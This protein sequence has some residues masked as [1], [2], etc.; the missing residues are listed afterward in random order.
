MSVEIERDCLSTLDEIVL[1]IELKEKELLERAYLHNA[2]VLIWP[3]TSNPPTFSEVAADNPGV[4][5]HVP[6]PRL[7]GATKEVSGFIGEP[8]YV[9]EPCAL[10]RW[11]IAALVRARE[12]IVDELTLLSTGDILSLSEPFV[13][14]RNQ[15]LFL[16]SQIA[17]LKQEVDVRAEPTIQDNGEKGVSSDDDHIHNKLIWNGVGW[18]LYFKGYPK[19]TL[20]DYLGFRYLAVLLRQPK[21]SFFP[22]DLET[23]VHGDGK[24][25][26]LDRF[27]SLK[28]KN[29]D[30]FLLS[31][32]EQ[33]D[34]SRVGIRAYGIPEPAD[35]KNAEGSLELVE[36]SKKDKSRKG[37]ATEEIDVSGH[38]NAIVEYKSAKK[39][40]TKI[41]RALSSTSP[42]N[43]LFR[44]LTEKKK[45]QEE[46]IEHYKAVR[47]IS[48]H[49]D[50]I[51]GDLKTICAWLKK[52]PR[53]EDFAAEVDHTK[54][55]K[56]NQ[57]TYVPSEGTVWD[58][59]DIAPVGK[60]K[61]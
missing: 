9:L 57:F 24:E 41:D 17:K 4:I 10:P 34:Q 20:P 15:L 36:Y 49:L 60:L 53:F 51:R 47:G 23:A 56:D 46:I 18:D 1:L 39:M 2:T 59:I 14:N 30:S 42:D 25:A 52:T 27:D 44:E 32:D 37:G 12:I 3:S 19:Q 28:Q 50:A 22:A 11:Q 38:A 55:T 35:K 21:T 26:M 61:K 43:R 40:L 45:Q 48:K 54:R 16:K 5:F 8:R 6:D 13:V 29:P 7:P 31:D 33:F 58:T